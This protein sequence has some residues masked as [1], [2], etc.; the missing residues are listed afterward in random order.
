MKKG[1]LRQREYRK[2]ASGQAKVLGWNRSQARL[3]AG[4]RYETKLEV[5]EWRKAYY[6]SRRRE[7]RI[8]STL[9]VLS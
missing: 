4:R 8:R 3:E 2:T 9:T 1:T 7:K 5:R 6:R